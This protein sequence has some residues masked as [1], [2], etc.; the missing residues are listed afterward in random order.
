MLD[1]EELRHPLDRRFER[2]RER[3]V[4]DRL[5][6]HVEESACP[7]ELGGKRARA[8]TDPERLR[9]AQRRS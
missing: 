9:G 2:V 6:E 4:R 5:A 1:V 7:L 3:K 8:L